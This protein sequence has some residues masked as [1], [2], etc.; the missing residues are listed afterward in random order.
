MLHLKVI[1][2]QSK[3]LEELVRLNPIVLFFR[4]KIVFYNLAG[5]PKKKKGFRHWL[6]TKVGE[7][8]VLYSKS[9]SRIQK[10]T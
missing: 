2:K 7:P 6:K 5:T 3:Q 9:R 8:P 10:S 1:A 4:D